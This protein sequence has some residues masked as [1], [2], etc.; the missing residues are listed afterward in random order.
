MD[1]IDYRRHQKRCLR[2][3]F[4]F[5]KS[6][7]IDK[8]DHQPIDHVFRRTVRQNTQQIPVAVDGLHFGVFKNQRLQHS[9]GIVNQMVIFQDGS[10]VAQ[11]PANIAVYQLDY[12]LGLAG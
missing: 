11:R 2:R 4:G 1:S 10:Q 5:F 6:A 8:T 9:L 12:R 7:Y 3:L